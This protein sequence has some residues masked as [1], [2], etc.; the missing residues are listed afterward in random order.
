M[1]SSTSQVNHTPRRRGPVQFFRVNPEKALVLTVLTGGLYAWYW[2]YQNWK[3]VSRS[4]YTTMP[5]LFGVLLHPISAFG[6]FRLMRNASTRAGYPDTKSLWL[7]GS[8]WFALHIVGLGILINLPLFLTSIVGYQGV[9]LTFMGLVIIG[10]WLIQDIQGG[11]EHY[12]NVTC[13]ECHNNDDIR[14]AHLGLSMAFF[15]I[16]LSTFFLYPQE[17]PFYPEIT[18]PEITI[19]YNIWSMS[20]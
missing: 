12:T 15:S 2:M 7:D 8:I 5:T 3:G 19:P 11:V 14:S 20:V 17:L 1:H 6:L 18:L 10:A 16:Y 4:G 9:G 13:P